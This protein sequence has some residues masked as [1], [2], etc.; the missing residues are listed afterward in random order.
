MKEIR[1]NTVAEIVGIALA[2]IITCGMLFMGF[3]I[4]K[5]FSS[6]AAKMEA[7]RQEEEQAEKQ[8]LFYKIGRNEAMVEILHQFGKISDEKME[9][10]NQA[11][12]NYLDNQSLENLSNWLDALEQ[13]LGE[14]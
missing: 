9:L 4:T 7:E 12:Q 11:K 5:Y 6:Q 8:I 2:V 1:K 14:N 3:A 10:A 13:T